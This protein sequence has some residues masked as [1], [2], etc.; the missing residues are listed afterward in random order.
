MRILARWHS[1]GRLV[2]RSVAAA[3]PIGPGLCR[4]VDAD[5]REFYFHAL[6]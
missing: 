1:A 4:I 5:F 2:T 3:E 6:G